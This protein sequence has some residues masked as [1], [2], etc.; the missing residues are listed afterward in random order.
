[1]SKR[2]AFE[3]PAKTHKR[4][5]MSK[6]S[7]KTST[8]YISSS[9][10]SKNSQSRTL[11]ESSSHRPSSDRSTQSSS[12]NDGPTSGSKQPG[13]P[14]KTISKSPT[15]RTTLPGPIH[16]G[17]GMQPTDL[18]HP[19]TAVTKDVGLPSPVTQGPSHDGTVVWI[20]DMNERYM[21]T[22]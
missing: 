3:P 8:S 22:R 15:P 10:S 17:A 11:S 18:V 13:T 7:T 5:A 12:P 14:P 1:M 2:S 6:T 20:S 19:T 21:L 4:Q 9:R 16:L